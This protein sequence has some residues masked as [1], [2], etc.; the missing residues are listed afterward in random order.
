[1]FKKLIQKEPRGQVVQNLKKMN[2][3][4]QNKLSPRNTA[5]KGTAKL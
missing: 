5:Q 4:F 1:M 2:A 3:Y